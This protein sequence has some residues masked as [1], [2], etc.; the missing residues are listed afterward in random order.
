M[1]DSWNIVDE[2]SLVT[3]AQLRDADEKSAA[4]HQQLFSHSIKTQ[5]RRR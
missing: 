3:E 2:P 5:V 1:S 4:Q